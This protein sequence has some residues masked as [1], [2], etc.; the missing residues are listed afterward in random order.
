MWAFALSVVA[1]GSNSYRMLETDVTQHPDFTFLLY[2]RPDEKP[3][4]TFEA[5]AL[6]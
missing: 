6:G 2:S 5:D 3:E 4:A 1:R